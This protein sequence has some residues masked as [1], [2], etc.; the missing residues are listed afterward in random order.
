VLF[1]LPH[2]LAA[3]PQRACRTA[4]DSVG[5]GV[6]ADAK[7]RLA[8]LGERAQTIEVAQANPMVERSSDQN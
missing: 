5:I 4:L 6:Q 7:K 1:G 8:F 2:D 3:M